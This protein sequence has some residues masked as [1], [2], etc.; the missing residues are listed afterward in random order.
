MLCL[1]VPHQGSPRDLLGDLKCSAH[2]LLI[3]SC[4][5]C[6][7]RPLAFYKLNLEHKN[8]DMK[9]CLEKIPT[10]FKFKCAEICYWIASLLNEVLYDTKEPLLP[11]IECNA[12][13]RQLC[14][15]KQT[16]QPILD[17]RLRINVALLQ[18]MT[19]KRKSKK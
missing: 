14:E 17:K 5:W 11:V 15:A 1:L 18:K 4:L 10:L 16:V 7:K 6:E 13:T 9:K 2:P 3:S 12:D 19:E 8:S